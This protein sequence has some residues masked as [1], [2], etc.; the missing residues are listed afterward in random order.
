MNH[1]SSI[2]SHT[3]TNQ[4]GEECIVAQDQEMQVP[5]HKEFS[6]NID[7]LL[8]EMRV[9]INFDVVHRELECGGRKM[10]MFYIDGYAGDDS[11][12]EVLKRL[13]DVS[14]NDLRRNPVETLVRQVIPHQEVETTDDLEEVISQ[15]LGGQA[16]FLVEGADQAILVDLREYPSR[17][18]EEPDIE[19]V[20]RGPR[21]G[22]VETIVFNCALIRRRVRDRSLVMEHLKIGRRSKTNIN[23]FRFLISL[24]YSQSP[25]T[26][27]GE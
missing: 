16:A 1:K 26:V 6:R 11:A 13:Y 15:V 27:G 4:Y 7:Y 5:L 19:R 10:G 12:I 25:T 8:R 22:F 23:F 3:N 17:S 9:E 24:H 2:S 21:D 18:P 20:V 14:A